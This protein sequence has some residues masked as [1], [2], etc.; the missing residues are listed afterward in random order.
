MMSRDGREVGKRGNGDFLL[1]FHLCT[2]FNFP[3]VVNRADYVIKSEPIRGRGG[4]F[5]M[6]DTLLKVKFFY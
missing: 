5:K 2:I 4:I 6:I 1:L 3:I